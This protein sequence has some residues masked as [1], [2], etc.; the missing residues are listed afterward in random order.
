[1]AEELTRKQN[2]KGILSAIAFI[3]FIVGVF[4]TLFVWKPWE[5]KAEER[6][7]DNGEEGPP[8]P[9]GVEVQ[10]LTCPNGYVPHWGGG[11]KILAPGVMGCKHTETGEFIVCPSRKWPITDDEQVIG[12]AYPMAGKTKYDG[13]YYPNPDPHRNHLYLVQKG[14]KYRAWLDQPNEMT[15]PLG[16]GISNKYGQI[17]KGMCQYQDPKRDPRETVFRI[18][19]Q[20]FLAK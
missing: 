20:V 9:P 18:D 8:P 12:L 2:I 6:D 16:G 11:G 14:N 7:I 5:K 15:C 10:C 13:V 19:P 3:L 4:W 17:R 1:M